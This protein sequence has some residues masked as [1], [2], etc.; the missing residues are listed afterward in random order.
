[1]TSFQVKSLQMVS[2]HFY[3]LPYHL[4]QSSSTHRYHFYVM[5]MYSHPFSKSVSFDFIEI[6]EI[7]CKFPNYTNVSTEHPPHFG[8]NLSGIGQP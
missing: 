5:C 4:L 2:L 6:A 7:Y 3:F 8:L 1:M